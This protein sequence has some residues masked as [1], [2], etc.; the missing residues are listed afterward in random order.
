MPLRRRVGLLV[1][2][3]RVDGHVL[4][5]LL[6]D[7]LLRGVAPFL[8]DGRACVIRC[9][10]HGH[11][12]VSSRYPARRSCETARPCPT[13]IAD[14]YR[15][16]LAREIAADA[17]ERFLRYVRIDTQA[18]PHSTTYPSTPKQLDLSRILVDELRQL[19]LEAELDEH[20]YVMAT[21][22]RR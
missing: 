14:G 2:P 22:P 9:L 3:V 20:G 11:L 13:N 10:G 17:L 7:A 15:T 12:L 18:D 19:G 5:A 21:F 6:V 1:D 8:V 4:G 16:E